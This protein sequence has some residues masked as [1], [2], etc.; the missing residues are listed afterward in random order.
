MN[1]KQVSIPA[2]NDFRCFFNPVILITIAIVFNTLFQ[3][4][5]SNK[6]WNSFSIFNETP[7]YK[8]LI[9][10]LVFYVFFLI[11]AFIAY[12]FKYPSLGRKRK[13]YLYDESFYKKLFNYILILNML[14]FFICQYYMNDANLVNIYIGGGVSAQTIEERIASSPLGI[15]GVSLLLGYLGLVM[16]G[17]SRLTNDDRKIVLLSLLII[18]VKFISYAKLQ[19]LLYVFF[20]MMLYS[21]RRISIN[22]GTLIGLIIVVLFAFTRIIRNPE[23]DLSFSFNFLFRFIGGFYFGSPVVNFSYVVKNNIHDLYYFF[24]WF[25]PQKIIPASAI[26]LEFPDIT[27]PIG[28]VGSAYVSLGIFSFVYAYI[29]GFIVQYMYLQRCNSPVSY[30]FQ[31]FLVMACIF[32]M[33]YNNFVNVNFFILPLIFTLW[34]VRRTISI[35]GSN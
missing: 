30:I 4:Y 17:M 23:Q 12:L 26:N 13:F 25:V 19:S 18:I 33:M 15:H 35:K 28:F 10:S 20:A 24:N 2:N 1:M 34:V 31:P 27:S 6:E 32:S 14:T 8:V 11:G 29:V 3:L 16:L 21:K 5:T 9:I 22:K 7:D